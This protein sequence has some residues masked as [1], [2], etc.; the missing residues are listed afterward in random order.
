MKIMKVCSRCNKNRSLSKFRKD[1]RYRLGVF[2]WCKDCC[3][4]YQRL[5]SQRKRKA[6]LLKNKMKDPQFAEK[7]RKRSLDKYHSN[8]RKHKNNRMLR[9]YGISLVK[10]EITK[11]CVLCGAEGPLVADHNHK[12]NKYRGALCSPCNTGIGWIERL[13]SALIKVEKYLKRG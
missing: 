10:F 1:S 9:M 4:E 3:S 7:E 13:S 12:T 11:R 8:P 2:A 5:P 6:E